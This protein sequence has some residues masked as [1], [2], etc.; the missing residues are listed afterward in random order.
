MKRCPVC[1]AEARK[2]AAHCMNCGAA[3]YARPAEASGPD[4]VDKALRAAIITVAAMWVVTIGLWSFWPRLSSAAPTSV[5]AKVA[6]ANPLPQAAGESPTPE[7]A[8]S[9]SSSPEQTAPPVQTAA[10]TA[11]PAASPDPSPVHSPAAA[12][13]TDHLETFT[14]WWG[15]WVVSNYQGPNPPQNNA[16]KI[17][18]YIGMVTD[19][20]CFFEIYDTRDVQDDTPAL[21]SYYIDL[22]TRSLTPIIGEKDAWVLDR[23]LDESDVEPLTLILEDGSLKLSYHYVCGE[24]SFDL[25]CMLVPEN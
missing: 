23:Y 7:P 10:P 1:G 8:P 15:Y 25:F 2:G 21:I 6:L 17:W 9:P 5:S 14:W 18:A 11:A 4:R 20:R 24:E 12:G 16:S 13:P 22:Q 3:L 19:G